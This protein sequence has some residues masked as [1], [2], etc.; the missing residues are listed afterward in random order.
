M[1]SRTT[2][3]DGEAFRVEL[4]D[5]ECHPDKRIAQ[6]HLRLRRWQE[7]IGENN[8][9]DIYDSQPDLRSIA[10]TYLNGGQF[11]VAKNQSDSIIGFVG[12]KG[13]DGRVATLKRL[14]VMPEYQ[15][16]GVGSR[17]VEALVRWSRT[18]GF[19]KIQLATGRQE[20]ARGIYEKYGFKVTGINKK[21]DDFMMELDF[22]DA[23]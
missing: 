6:L 13:N 4:Y 3:H 8:F 1:I 17:L 10:Q 18:S 14:A 16:M 12:L 5:S 11:F 23:I 2:Q 9:H 21:S 19:E 15:G 22:K 20:R 7:K